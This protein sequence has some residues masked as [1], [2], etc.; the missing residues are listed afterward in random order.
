MKKRC[1]TC[2]WFK[3]DRNPKTG[4]ILPSVAAVCTWDDFEWPTE[5][6][7]AYTQVYR[8][9]VK[10]SPSKTWADYGENCPCWAEKARQPGRSRSRTV[11]VQ[12]PGVGTTETTG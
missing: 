6:P 10:P 1:G 8:G 11:Q 12:L 9:V 4:R 5:W 7:E 2:N 3:P